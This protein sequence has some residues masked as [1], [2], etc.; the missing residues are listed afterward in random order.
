MELT[1]ADWW[2]LDE[3]GREVVEDQLQERLPRGYYDL[4]A[5]GHGRQALPQFVH[6]STGV[7][8]H[9]VFGGPAVIGMTQKRFERL[10]LISYD[11]EE[12]LMVPLAQYDEARELRPARP[13]LVK[14]AL[15][16]SET[17]SFGV[18]K[19][20]GVD[21]A[22]LT[23]SAFSPVV[24]GAVLKA[25][26]PLKWRAPS[27]AE[28][29]Y[30]VRAV[31]DEVTDDPPSKPTGRLLACGLGR[32]GHQ[33][34]LCRDDWRDDLSELPEQGSCGSGHDVL[35]GRGNGAR[36]AGWGPSAAWNEALWPGRRR[37]ATWRSAVAI[38][39]W[40]DLVT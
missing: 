39:P 6:E 3:G 9:V 2:A 4:R 17:L 11:E 19:K 8:F 12:D 29:E 32:M 26:T 1:L 35:R 22:K 25:L 10:R 40:V 33:L 16:A 38:R 34:E 24:V 23:V 5:G 27:E 36:F 21:E 20:L 13:V 7:L 31:E 30:A 37:L 14:T 15:V 18:L 28:W